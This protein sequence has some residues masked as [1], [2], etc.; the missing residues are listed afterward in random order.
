MAILWRVRSANHHRASI[1]TEIPDTAVPV[2]A[3]AIQ[4][5]KTS[6]DDGPTVVATAE[7]L[8]KPWSS[9]TFV[10]VKPFSRETVDAM[11]IRLPG[12]GIWG[13][14][15]QEPYGHC[16]LEFVT[17]LRKL[18][19]QF[20]YRASHPMVVNPCNNTVYDPLEAG[21]LGNGVWVRGEIVQGGGLRPPMSINVLEKGQSIIADRME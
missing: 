10:F 15:L 21:P 17:D 16:T 8:A 9:K 2:P 14:A 11:A 18:A 3:P 12:K 6:V 5:P 19:S 7:E 4:P 1:E 13:F 20:G